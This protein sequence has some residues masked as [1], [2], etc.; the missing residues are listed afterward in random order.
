MSYNKQRSLTLRSVCIGCVLCWLRRGTCSSYYQ[1]LCC[2]CGCWA[3]RRRRRWI[4]YYWCVLS[5][6]IA[7]L[8]LNAAAGSSSFSPPLDWTYR[9]ASMTL[10]TVFGHTPTIDA[11][12]AVV[13]PGKC[14]LIIISCLL[15]RTI[16]PPGSSPNEKPTKRPCTAISS[17]LVPSSLLY[18]RP[19]DNYSPLRFVRGSDLC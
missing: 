2:C 6:G 15:Q 18:Y 5:C 12:A 9:S 10:S 7:T 8:R 1:C 14:I 13:A 17:C 11:A 4:N 19:R 3:R 16:R